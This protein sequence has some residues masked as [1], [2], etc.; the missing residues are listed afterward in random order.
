M[1]APASRP[2]T[3]K[4]IL[5]ALT[6]ATGPCWRP[7]KYSLFPPLGLAYAWPQYLIT[8]RMTSAVIVDEHVEPLALDDAP[9]PGGDPGLH[10]QRLPRVQDCRPLPEQRRVCV[11]RRTAR[12]FSSR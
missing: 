5:P 6:E 10:H 12:N 4:F 11:P 3:V 1:I 7:I 8:L 9:V 2:L